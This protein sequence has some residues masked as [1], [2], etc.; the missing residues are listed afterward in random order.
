MKFVNFT[1]LVQNG[2]TISVDI[3]PEHVSSLQTINIQ[4]E[5]KNGQG[6]PIAH[7]GT[8]IMLDGG[9]L[10]VVDMKKEDVKKILQGDE[11]NEA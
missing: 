7:P 1:V 10:F 8:G 3:V 4:G 11:K 5:L 9:A 6:L 2:G